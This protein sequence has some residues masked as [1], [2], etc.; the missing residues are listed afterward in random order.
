MEKSNE[1]TNASVGY[2]PNNPEPPSLRE[3]DPPVEKAALR[4]AAEYNKEKITPP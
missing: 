1:K 2:G 3:S 4:S